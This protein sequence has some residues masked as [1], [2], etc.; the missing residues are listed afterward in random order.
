MY[1]KQK[2][3]QKKTVFSNISRMNQKAPTM[4]CLES[5]LILKHQL[6]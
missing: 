6:S 5:I 2:K 3:N 1:L 4:I